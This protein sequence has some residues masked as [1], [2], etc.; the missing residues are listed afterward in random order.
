MSNTP[1]YRGMF[2]RGLGSQ[3]FS[4]NNGVHTGV[5]NTTYTS[6]NLGKIQGDAIRNIYGDLGTQQ[7]GG[8]TK[9]NEDGWQETSYGKLDDSFYRRV[10][11]NGWEY[12]Q[13]SF[14]LGRENR[15][16][17]GGYWSNSLDDTG[18]GWYDALTK[19]EYTPHISYGDAGGIR[20]VSDI[21]FDVKEIHPYLYHFAAIIPMCFSADI[22]V[23]TAN[24]NRPINVA[25]RYMIKAK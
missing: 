9:A 15:Y 12:V 8:A 14:P 20:Y 7:T 19:Y 16:V 5:T 2:L 23:P 1:D 24:E 11:S 13:T 25:V 4:Q 22:I 6:G 21:S 3:N 10:G 17:K 18:F